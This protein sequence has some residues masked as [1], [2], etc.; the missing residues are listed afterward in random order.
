MYAYA[1][2]ILLTIMIVCY[3]MLV[4]FG[5]MKKLSRKPKRRKFKVGDLVVQ[6]LSI[7]SMKPLTD[8]WSSAC[9]APVIFRIEEIGTLSYRTSYPDLPSLSPAGLYFDRED[10]YVTVSQ[11]FLEK[12]YPGSTAAGILLTEADHEEIL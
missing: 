6:R 7:E 8:E 12:C 4:V 11:E 2:F 10:G 9:D 3:C 1:L 5:F